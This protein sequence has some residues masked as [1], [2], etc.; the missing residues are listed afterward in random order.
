LTT[1]L[2][3]IANGDESA[4][5]EI[6][7]EF[8]GLIYR[9][10]RRYL[11]K[12]DPEIDDAVQDVF[13]EIWLSAK[14]FD[15]TKGSEA[16][17]IATLAHRR[18]IDAQR[19]AISRHKKARASTNQPRPTEPIAPIRQAVR[20]AVLED[21]AQRFDELPDDERQ[22]LWLAI[23]QGLTHNQIADALDTPVGTVKTR[24]RRALLR[25]GKKLQETQGSPPV[26]TTPKGG[27]S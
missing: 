2:E 25:L 8:G 26:P 20:S 13:V 15:P 10:A 21:I 18:L 22:P 12:V 3:R 19:R 7:D 23:H 24:L 5:R 17:F 4:V 1:R 16:S 27:A 9:L 14:R 11:D 6:I